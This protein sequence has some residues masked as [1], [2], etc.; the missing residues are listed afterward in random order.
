MLINVNEELVRVRLPELL[1]EYDC[2]KCEKCVDDMLAIVLNNLK[3]QY[4]NSEKGMLIRRISSTL[5]QTTADMD[6]EII[7]S[8]E[9]VSSHPM[10]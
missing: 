7:K 2:C 9:K 1:E 8:I 10:H 5:P 4:V 3:P 6:I